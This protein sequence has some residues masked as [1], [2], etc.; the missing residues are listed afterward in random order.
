M[1]AILE[2]ATPVEITQWGTLNTAASST[3][4][5]PGQTPDADNVWVDEKPGSVMTA[6]G[7]L[8]VGT[9]PSNLPPT[10]MLTYFKSSEG[11]QR[12]IVS[13]NAT[14]WTTT[15]FVN[16]TSLI[17]GLSA[18]FQLRAKVIRDKVWFTNGSDSVRVYDG[19]SVTVL[20]GTHAT[21]VVQDITY[22]SGNSGISPSKITI[23]YTTGGTAGS[24]VVT[25]ANLSQISVKIQSGVSTATQVLAAI[26]GSA[27]ALALISAAIT[28]TAGNAQTAPFGPTA[29]SGGTPNV[30][31]GRFIE[32]KDERVWLYHISGAR[33]S[34]NFSAVG[35]N[36]GNAIT[37]DDL[38][39][40]PTSNQ[41]QIS[42]GDNDFGTGIKLY[43]GYLYCF[44]QYTIWR[45]TGYD[46]SS[47]SRVKT[48]ASTG[49]RFAESIQELD[50]VLKFIGI[51]GFYEF[52]GEET[53]RISDLID[54]ASAVPGT[55]GFR[56]LQQPFLNSEFWS[57]NDTADFVAGTVPR[58]I[59]TASDRAT[60][61]P[62][63]DLQAD[64]SAAALLD[65]I[66]LNLNPD[67]V[68][69]TVADATGTYAN[70]DLAVGDDCYFTNSDTGSQRRTP[71]SG[72]MS[73]LVDGVGSKQVIMRLS[74]SLTQIYVTLDKYYPYGRVNLRSLFLAQGQFGDLG[75]LFEAIVEGQV[76]PGFWSTF[77]SFNP[78]YS[79]ADYS[80]G[81]GA[82]FPIL[83]NAIRVTLV[84]FPH[85]NMDGSVRL[86]Q[87][88]FQKQGYAPTGKIVSR[89]LNY[90]QIPSSMGTFC[91]K[92]TLNNQ[93]ISFFTQTSSD[94]IG[95]GPE[96]AVTSGAAIGSATAQYA[97]WGA[98]LTSDGTTTPTI[99]SVF[100]MGMYVSAIHDAGASVFAWGAYEVNQ[101]TEAG[102]ILHFYRG[103][104]TSGAVGAAAWLPIVPGAA[105][106]IA[107]DHE[108]VQFKFEV[109]GT[110]ATRNPYVDDVTINW[111]NTDG[112]SV[113]TLQNVASIPWHNRYWLSAALR[114]SDHDNIVIIRGKKTYGA[115]W[116][117]K[118]W[119]ILSYNIYHG[120]LY[121]GS[122]VDGSIFRL[123]YGT[124]LNGVAMDSYFET[125]DFEKG[126]FIFQILE[127][128]VEVERLGPYPLKFGISTDKGLTF[129][130]KDI[131]LTETGGPLTYVKKL[132][133]NITT[134]KARLR[135]R[136]SGL[137]QPFQVHNV[138]VWYQISA[139]RGSIK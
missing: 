54:P 34:A 31:K 4:L 75:T 45:V 70:G 28:G 66:D 114:G 53:Q 74:A 64:F 33:S 133:F 37:P 80:I 101:S 81:S 69:L 95:W 39:A 65:H 107:V 98:Y 112:V 68:S 139:A 41:L 51:D 123:D 122:S 47:Y 29:L 86:N 99:D 22:T 17:T 93:G 19:T 25:V 44:K 115:P 72:Q 14:V 113:Q 136:T 32:Y 5:S 126:G 132:L 96:V 91:A 106:S 103:A 130:E 111:V 58:N 18:L 89:T 82:G 87:I 40:W 76:T 20:S 56:D 38:A 118:S 24:E 27:A 73:D 21:L 12:F 104:T 88:E 1:T 6:L 100:M 42:E 84:F 124:N 43:R 127:V 15:D 57:V 138:I 62:S 7:F 128:E 16:Y 137:D 78:T 110:D 83:V 23:A 97:R 125:G 50:G 135:V 30:P 46:E 3:K 63:D 48:R 36:A 102:T 85:A 77:G 49:T 92:Y 134:D 90:G 105:L 59:S 52:D 35:D 119:S 121:G 109:S 79:A 117:K 129:T 61:E 8:K 55:F 9:V 71:D 116:Q 94:G 131:D 60:L 10:L 67:Q 2:D 11:S 13:D 26:N 120:N 108:F